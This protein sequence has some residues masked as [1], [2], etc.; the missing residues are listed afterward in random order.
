VCFGLRQVIVV[1]DLCSVS[2][3]VVVCLSCPIA[4][5]MT[6]LST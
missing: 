4:L 2:F 3:A 6:N 5:W 1:C